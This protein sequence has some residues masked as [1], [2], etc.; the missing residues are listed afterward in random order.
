MR[1]EWRTTSPSLARSRPAAPARRWA[2]P[3]TAKLAKVIRLRVIFA[4]VPAPTGPKCAS[5]VP[6]SANGSRHRSTASSVP[7][8]MIASVPSWAPIAPPETGASTRATPASAA[9]AASATAPSALIVECTATTVR[10]P[11]AARMPSGP[12]STWR[13]WS[14]FCTMTLMTSAAA[15]TWAGVAAAVAPL[16]T[17]GSQASGRTSCTTRP[18]GHPSSRRAIGAPMLP[19]PM[20]PTAPLM[21][22]CPSSFMTAPPVR[23]RHR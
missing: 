19:N 6:I 10:G 23:R 5:R 9:S 20:N 16:A 15:A 22:A 13:T 18:P 8:I 1:S 21:L 2:S 17:Y 4:L 3:T 12:E 14:S 7:P 11:A